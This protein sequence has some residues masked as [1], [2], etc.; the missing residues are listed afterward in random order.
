MSSG[1]AKMKGRRTARGLRGQAKKGGGKGGVQAEGGDCS[2]EGLVLVE[3]CGR[4]A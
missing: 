1:N 3:P 2:S 4:V